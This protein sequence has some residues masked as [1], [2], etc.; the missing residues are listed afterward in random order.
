[1]RGVSVQ[2]I[3]AIIGGITVA[4]VVVFAFLIILCA[5]LVDYCDNARIEHARQVQAKRF[6]ERDGAGQSHGASGK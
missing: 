2:D 5:V 6:A 1:M 4:A 3:L